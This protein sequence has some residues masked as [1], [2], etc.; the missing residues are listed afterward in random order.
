MNSDKSGN[1]PN[2]N[3]EEEKVDKT[4]RRT[5]AIE[6]KDRDPSS[7]VDSLKTDSEDED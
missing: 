2:E 6:S 4:F 7:P 1:F 3:N 5:K